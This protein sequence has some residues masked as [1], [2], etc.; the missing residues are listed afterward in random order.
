MLQQAH[1]HY[2]T[3]YSLWTTLASEYGKAMVSTVFKDFKDYLAGRIN[4][5]LDLLPYFDKAFA[6]YRHMA[7]S[8]ITVP[9]PTPGNDCS[10]RS[11][12]EMGDAHLCHHW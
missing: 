3:S 6:A 9:P 5:N 10:C 11:P 2:M 12:S 8:D 4:T 1:A 7:T